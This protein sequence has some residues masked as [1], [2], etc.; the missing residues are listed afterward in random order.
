[1]IDRPN[2]EATISEMVC[3]YS[4]SALGCHKN[5]L[6]LRYFLFDHCGTTLFLQSYFGWQDD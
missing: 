5:V 1:M 6:G 4:A 2:T 3:N